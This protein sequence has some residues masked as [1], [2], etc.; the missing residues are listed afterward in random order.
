VEIIRRIYSPDLLIRAQQALGA[1][2]KELAQLLGRSRRTIIRYQARGGAGN[3][4]MSDWHTLAR[5]IHPRD[6]AMAETIATATGETLV[7]LGL[8]SPTPPPRPPVSP[9]DLADALVCAASEAAD[10]SP[11]AMRPALV[12]AFERASASG[13]SNEEILDALRPPRGARPPRV[14]RPVKRR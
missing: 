12:A 7:T 1:T 9:R 13:F 11:R 3:L 8:E 14:E 2:Q 4:S 10:V 5:A 6:R